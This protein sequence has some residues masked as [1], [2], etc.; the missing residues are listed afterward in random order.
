MDFFD[1]FSCECRAYGRLKEAQREDVAVR[2][3]GYLLLTPTQEAEITTKSWGERYKPDVE[4][5]ELNSTKPWHRSE[6]HRYLP[7][8]CIVKDLATSP[9]H[10]TPSQIKTMWRDLEHFHRLG[11]LVRDIGVGNFIG[12]KII[13]LSRAWTTP[14]PAFMYLEEYQLDEHR[15]L[16]LQRLRH[17]II[18]FADGEG[19]DWRQ[20][21]IPEDLTKCESG[22]GEGE[23]DR[24]G[25]DPRLYDWRKWE[26]DP[27]EADRFIEEEM[28]LEDD[29]VDG[30]QLELRGE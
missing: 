15:R 10:F 21:K 18:D 6:Q 5:D 1:P 19:W 7:I 13:D 12:G 11:I 9:E 24:F 22:K 25:V 4:E 28:A 16:D 29:V 3:H 8:R 23:L 2:A 30:E 14:H 27:A 26:E 20:V 17:A